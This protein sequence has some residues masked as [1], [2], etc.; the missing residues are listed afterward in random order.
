MRLPL[1]RNFY[2][3]RC[4]R[5]IVQRHGLMNITLLTTHCGW[6]SMNGFILKLLDYECMLH[7]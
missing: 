6:L 5:F 3:T 2:V 1:E 4:V 7:G